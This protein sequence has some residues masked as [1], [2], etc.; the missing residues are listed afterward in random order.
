MA[1]TGPWR[2]IVVRPRDGD[3]TPVLT[4]LAAPAAAKIACLV[5]AR[6]RQENFF[7]YSREHQGMDQLLGYA[8]GEADGERLVPN[9]QRKQLERELKVKR[10]ELARGRAELGQALLDEPAWG[11]TA[12]G[13]KIAQRGAVGQLRALEDEIEALLDRRAELPVR[14]PLAQ[15]GRREVL[16]LEHKAIIDRVKITAYNAEEW[17]LDL[18]VRHYPNPHDVRALL[19]SF[20]ELSGEMRTTAHGVVITLDPPDIPLHRRALRG[21]CADLNQITTAYPGTEL[22]LIY[23][24]AMH[25]SEVAA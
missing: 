22:P 21:L 23:E 2:R 11:R 12:H 25:H 3:Q 15:A 20:A 10:Q 17:L 19:R 8:L 24:V 16:R 18:L 6:W 1:C 13:L 5:F 9:P 7:K 14:I 4:S